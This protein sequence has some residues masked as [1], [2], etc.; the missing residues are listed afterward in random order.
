MYTLSA[1]V[2][3]SEGQKSTFKAFD[4]EKQIFQKKPI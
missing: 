1:T 2:Q 4:L 3:T